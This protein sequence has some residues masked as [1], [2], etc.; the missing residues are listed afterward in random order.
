MVS[1]DHSATEGVAARIGHVFRNK[2]LL[3]RAFTHS[4]FR[5][6]NEKNYQALEFLGD[7]VLGLIVADEL[8]RRDPD[9][10]EGNLSL[11]FKKL[12]RTDTLAEIAQE[13]DLASGIRA[14]TQGLIAVQASRNVLADICEALIAAIYL[15]GGL[16]SAR[17]FVLRHWAERLNDLLPDSKDSKSML[18]EWTAKKD[19]SLP[20]YR[21]LKRT[22]PKHDHTFFVKVYVEGLEPAQGEGKSKRDAEQNAARVLLVREGVLV[23]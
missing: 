5:E 13:L 6:K 14:E 7:R 21:E 11:R 3:V 9:S 1:K 4:S 20:S 12:V 23:D 2:K 18:Q 16:E 22:G 17:A 8:H 10:S 15:D 19:L